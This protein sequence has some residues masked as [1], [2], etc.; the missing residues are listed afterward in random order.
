M[1]RPGTMVWLCLVILVGWAMF[2]VKYEVMQQEQ[3]LAG[4]NKRI[5]DEREQVRVL[6]AE[7]SYLTRPA[8]LEQLANRFLTLAPVG[9][10]QIV[11][12]RAIPERSDT[13]AANAPAVPASTGSRPALAKAEP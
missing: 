8:R 6:E 10:A 9:A 12:P 11:E 13:P 3:T 1:I 7:W 2:Q 4:L 5:G